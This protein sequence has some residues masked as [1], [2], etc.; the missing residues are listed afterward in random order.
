[1]AGHT[2]HYSLEKQIGAIYVL[3]RLFYGFIF[4]FVSIALINTFSEGESLG[5]ES[6]IFYGCWFLGFAMLTVF[7]AYIEQESVTLTDDC[8]VLEYKWR[9]QALRLPYESVE[10]IETAFV[11]PSKRRG[12]FLVTDEEGEKSRVPFGLEWIRFRGVVA[13]KTVH[14]GI[15]EELLT[16]GDALVERLKSKGVQHKERD[17]SSTTGDDI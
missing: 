11:F 6:P 16:E 17:M 1:M 5:F 7:F 4:G 3:V 10:L 14:V 12:L 13:G 15:P 2:H 8:I 9:K